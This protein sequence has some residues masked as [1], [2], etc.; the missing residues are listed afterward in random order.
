MFDTTFRLVSFDGS[1]LPM[2]RHPGG[3]AAHLL[4][5]R[6]P[7]PRT[8]RVAPR[9]VAKS[10]GTSQSNPPHVPHA[11]HDPPKCVPHHV[12]H[13]VPIADLNPSCAPCPPESCSVPDAGPIAGFNRSHAP[14]AA[15][16]H[17]R[18]IPSPEPTFESNPPHASHSSVVRPDPIP[19]SDRSVESNLP[20]FPPVERLPSP[21]IYLPIRIPQPNSKP[22]A[23][24]P[25][26]DS[27]P[28]VTL[29]IFE[30]LFISPSVR[31]ELRELIDALDRGKVGYEWPST[32][33]LRKVFHRILDKIVDS[34]SS[35]P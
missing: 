1:P 8:L 24:P 6:R 25:E 33:A 5:P 28:H 12:P 9:S 31:T 13:A 35:S 3:V 7:P 17:L 22:I 20:H 21:P 14:P 32:P 29:S 19:V 34:L 4:S 2:T 15:I 26:D 10:P 23:D 30:I 27:S 16:V 11:P 18:H